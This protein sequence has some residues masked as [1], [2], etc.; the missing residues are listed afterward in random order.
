MVFIIQNTPNREDQSIQIKLDELIRAQKGAKNILLDIEA[1]TQEEL[2]KIKKNIE[3]QE[4]LPELSSLR[5][6]QIQKHLRCRGLL[7][8]YHLLRDSFEAY[9]QWAYAPHQS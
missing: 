1:L 3:R 7:L 8:T 2:E 9:P 5:K 4:R 6:R